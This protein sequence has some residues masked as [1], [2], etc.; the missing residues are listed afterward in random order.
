MRKSFFLAFLVTM[1]ASILTLA[2]STVALAQSDP[3]AVLKKH[4]DA[5]AKGDV[6]GALALY[7]T[8]RTPSDGD[9]RIFQGAF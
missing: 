1:L 6:A 7:L 4:V 2:V 9:L 3:A 5:I 8:F